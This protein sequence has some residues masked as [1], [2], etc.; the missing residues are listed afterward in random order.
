MGGNDLIEGLDGNDT[1]DGGSG[2]N[3]LNGGNGDDSIIPA[4]GTSVDDDSVVDG[5]DGEDV[6]IADFS[7]AD[8]DFIGGSVSGDGLGIYNHQEGINTRHFDGNRIL[9]YSNLEQLNLIGTPYNDDLFGN[10]GDTLDGGEKEDRLNLNLSDVTSEIDLDLSDSNNQ[11]TGNAKTNISNFERLGIISTGSGDDRIIGN[12][13]NTT[14]INTATGNDTINLS[15]QA[16]V[17][18]RGSIDG[19]EGEDVL[20]ADFSNA[21]HN[22]IGGGNGL[23]IYNHQDGINTRHFNDNQILTYSNLEQFN[24]IGTKYND[25]FKVKAEDKIDGAAGIDILNLDLSTST[26]NYNLDLSLS[27]SQLTGDEQTQVK[28]FEAFGSIATGSGNDIIKLASNKAIDDRGSVDTG[29]GEDVLIADFS[30]ADDNF[31][32]GG[33][34]LGIYNHQDGIN[35]RHFDGNQ[36]LTYSNLEQLHLTGTAFNDSLQGFDDNDRLNGNAGDD[37]LSGVDPNSNNFG[38][39]E[40]D[41]LEGG[42]GQDFFLLSNGVRALYDDRDDTTDGKEDYV[43]IT[44]LTIAEDKIKLF[45]YKNIYRLAES[46]FDISDTAIYLKKPDGEPDELIAIIEEVTDLDINSNVFTYGDGDGDRDRVGDS[47]GDPHLNTFDGVSYDFQAVGEFTFVKSTTDDFEIQVR[48]EPWGNSTSVSVNTAVAMNIEGEDIGLYLDR[49]EPL[50]V[51]GNSVNLANGGVF[52]VGDS[53]IFRQGNSYTINSP[54]NDQIKVDLNGNHLNIN[55]GLSSSRD[56]QI[57]GLLGN[58]NNERSD[59]FSLRDGTVIGSSISNEQ[60]YGEYAD[61][62][63]ITQEES[64]FDYNLESESN[65]NIP[66]AANLEIAENN[67]IFPLNAEPETNTETFTDRNFPYEIVT[68]DTLDPEVK[69]EAEAIASAAGITD[70]DLL[71]DAILDIALTDADAEFIEGYTDLQREATLNGS[72][73]LINPDGEGE[74]YEL[75]ASAIIPYTIRFSNN[76]ESTTSPVAQVT[77]TQQL[78]SDLDFDTFTLDDISFGNINLDV[79]LGVQNY[80]E[81][82]DLQDSLGIFVD[83]FAGLDK[84]TGIVSWT[85]TSIDP[86]TGNLVTEISQ[87]FLP[88]NDENDSGQGFVGYSIQPQADNEPGTRID[89]QASITFDDLPSI[90]TAPVF[91]TIEGNNPV[92][93]SPEVKSEISNVSVNEDAEITVIDLSN[94]FT[95]IDNDDSAIIKSVFANSNQSLVTASIN[96]NN[97]ILDYQNNQSGTAEI[98]V[99]G[100]SNGETIQDMF[101][102][103]VNPVNDAPILANEIP[104]LTVQEDSEFS[105]TIP[106]NTFTDV[107]LGTNLNYFLNVTNT[108]DFPSWL[109]VVDSNSGTFGT[110]D[111]TPTNDDVGTLEIEIIAIDDDG[112]SATGTFDLIVENVDDAPE[113]NNAINDLIVDQNADNTVIDLRDV[114]TDIDNDDSA[115][116]KTISSNSNENLVNATI[117]GDNLTLDYQDNQSGTADITVQ[118]T[119]NGQTV[120]STFSLTVNEVIPVID[121]ANLSKTNVHRFYQYEKGFHL[122][123]SDENEIRVVRELSDSG[124]LAYN[125]EDEKYTVLTDDRDILTGEAIEGVKPVYRFFNTDTGAH[126]YT[127]DENEKDHIQDNLSNYNFEGIKYYAFESEPEVL[128]TVPVFRMLNSLSGAHLFTVDQNEINHIQEHLPQF[129]IEGNGGIAF[130]VFEL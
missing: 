36:I 31:I 48:Q 39:G 108:S 88:P 90:E 92:D 75:A 107:D 8:D 96:G 35:T 82:L 87:G 22:F 81:R 67:N 20:I 24:L 28:N 116:I 60:L 120:D 55:A 47:W 29:E 33:N 19:G 62:W 103:N 128:E 46:P 7:N 83:V 57:V 66:A 95:D 109:F 14:E 23:G 84:E 126:I 114:F 121:E 42:L 94:V 44:D 100:E 6:L 111:D 93:N 129:S 26:K 38:Q 110:F 112:A 65:N 105:F 50:V 91:N 41:T 102:I 10:T 71:E 76:E 61:S 68:I 74:N 118:G 52:V 124:E 130:H 80:S 43:K 99:Q 106:E 27:G 104:S 115:I 51:N 85:F 73:T 21:D 12:P 32:G 113:I 79:P 64:L 45:G 25:L 72:N 11:V 101:T 77:I 34:G 69:A 119:S 1:L 15:D 58:S 122:Y 78:D 63:R 86:D 59:D 54:E 3:I 16:G 56:G 89:A 5:G 37:I 123:T 97:L 2:T 117:E 53:L 70:P 127:M 17:D 49:A 9:T 30:N 40:I 13:S 98:T 125:Y 4:T 18:D